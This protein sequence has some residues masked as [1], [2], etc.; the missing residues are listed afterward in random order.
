MLFCQSCGG[1]F[2]AACRLS[3][4]VA[5]S[6][7]EIAKFLADVTFDLDGF[8]D[9]REMSGSPCSGSAVSGSSA[10]HAPP[11]DPSGVRA[12]LSE[13]L[14]GSGLIP[15]LLHAA[16]NGLQRDVNPGMPKWLETTKEKGLLFS[17]SKGL[18]DFCL[19]GNRLPLLR[20]RLVQYQKPIVHG[21]RHRK[22][23]RELPYVKQRLSRLCHVAWATL[24]GGASPLL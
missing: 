16:L 1:P 22:V 18:E 3:A 21:C 12:R 15:E 23:L 10:S 24:Q 11:E 8:G 13:R 7:P 5:S 17:R 19:D 20:R 9:S 14:R 6:A 2:T 4:S